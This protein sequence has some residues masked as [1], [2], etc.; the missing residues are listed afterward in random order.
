MQL[1]DTFGR[2]HDN[3]RISVTDRCNIRCQYCMPEEAPDYVAR[4]EILTFEEITRFAGIASQ[5]GITKLRVTGGEPLVRK[6]IELLIEALRQVPGIDDLALTTNAVLL[7]EK[8]PALY[9]AGL[10]RLNIHV[11]TLDRERFR[12]ITRRDDLPRVLAG[13]DRALELGF[14][15]IKINAVA[16]KGLTEPDILPLAHFGRERDI[17]IRFIEFMPLDAQGL[18][19]RTRLLSAAEIIEVLSREIAPLEEV[20]G[21]DPRAPAEE[22]AYADGRGR[23][24]FIASVSRPFC[25]SCN[26]IRITA[27]GKLRYC[28]FAI[29]ETDVKSLLRGGA[30]DREIAGVIRAVISRKWAGHAINTAQF[31]PPPR[32]MYAIGG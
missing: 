25:G 3:L 24:G 18:W 7:A 11:D 4:A 15:P 28:L 20:P 16:V 9:E 30:S 31:V 6:H 19:D 32:P 10:R 14:H 27:D 21:R 26:R 1:V 17:E 23:V 22:Y 8:A 2:L 29:E 13:I 5:L 12:Q